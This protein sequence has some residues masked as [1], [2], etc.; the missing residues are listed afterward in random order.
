[1]NQVA[2]QVPFPFACQRWRDRRGTYRPPSEVISTHDYEV[3]PI[4]L[5]EAKAFVQQHHYSGAYVACRFRYGLFLRYG[6]FPEDQL[7]G[8]AV[9]SMPMSSKVLTNVFPCDV[10]EA[11]ELGRFVL[12]DNVPSNAESWFF[13]RCRELLKREGIKGVVAFSDDTPRTSI[14]PVHSLIFSGHIGTIYQSSNA[15]YLKRTTPRVLRVLRDGSIFSDRAASKIRKA[16]RGWRYAANILVKN[17]ATE[18]PPA[19]PANPTALR[20]WLTNWTTL[21]TRPLKHPGNHRYAWSLSDSIS[22]PPSHV[23]PKWPSPI[24]HNGVSHS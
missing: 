20:T 19:N 7:V 2:Q 4:T 11:A 9:F 6:Q 23:Y 21:L 15:V 1:M 12:L 14:F 8:V 18:P 17:G 5:L 24:N 3:A 16:D 10:L 22:L 13:A